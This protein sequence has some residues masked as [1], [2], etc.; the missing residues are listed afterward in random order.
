MVVPDDP[1]QTGDVAGSVIPGRT[2]PEDV[3]GLRRADGALVLVA[4]RGDW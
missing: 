2:L 1:G 4:Y 3:L